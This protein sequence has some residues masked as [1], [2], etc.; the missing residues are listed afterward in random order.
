MPNRRPGTLGKPAIAS[1][2]SLFLL[3]TIL[4]PVQPANAQLPDFSLT[5]SF[6][7]EDLPPREAL[8][9]ITLST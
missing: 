9:T 4:R 3:L 1:L 6:R 7:G 8:T 5:M 2:L